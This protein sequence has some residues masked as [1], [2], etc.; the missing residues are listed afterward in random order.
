MQLVSTVTVGAGGA[1]TIEFTSIPQTGTDLLLVVSARSAFGGATDFYDITFNNNTSS[2]YSHRVL[3]GDGNASSSTSGGPSA[4]YQRD[5]LNGSTSTAST[6]SS[7]ALYIP[8]YTAAT[9]KS[10]A[11]DSTTENNAT[12]AFQFIVAGLFNSTAAITSIKYA[13]AFAANYVQGSTA[14]LYII[15]KA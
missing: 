2:V 10:F 6:F 9:A 14:S 5:R 3:I 13:T 11:I 7:Q 12:Q 8:N 4:S 1:A 15:T